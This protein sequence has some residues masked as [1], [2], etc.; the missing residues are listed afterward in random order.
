MTNLSFSE[1][2][3]V[4]LLSG[5]G[6]HTDI[7]NSQYCAGIIL[8]GIYDLISS[9]CVSMNARGGLSVNSVLPEEYFYLDTLYQKIRQNNKKI[10]SWLEY[11]C[12]S[13]TSKHI[14]PII[15]DVYNSL[16]KKGYINIDIK[17]GVFRT[18]THIHL[19][20]SKVN[21]I[22]ED[23]QRKT[24][25]KDEDN[26]VVFSVQML[27]L[28]DVLKD[29]F[30]LGQRLKLNSAISHYKKYDMWKNTEKYINLIR[31]FVY[32]NSVNSGAIYSE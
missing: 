7:T 29:F 13:S 20:S 8:G 1:S 16:A 21:Q 11:Y 5:I 32:Q 25:N 3:T 15:D 18:R 26:K 12:C 2:Y 17:K 19:C 14:R 27:L 10:S 23:F 31:N 28:A 6:K 24:I 22:I 4:L 9:G 30:T